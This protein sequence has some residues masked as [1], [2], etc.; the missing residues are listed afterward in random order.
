MAIHE[1][2]LGL[3]VKHVDVNAIGEQHLEQLLRMV[4]EQYD[5]EN[6]DVSIRN[7]HLKFAELS[8]LMGYISGSINVR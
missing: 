1:I 7:N 6:V 2:R 8:F 5:R 3:I 4:R